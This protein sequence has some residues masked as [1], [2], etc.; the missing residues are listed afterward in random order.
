MRVFCFLPRK[1]AH[2]SVELHFGNRLASQLPN[3]LDGRADGNAS[4]LLLRHFSVCSAMRRAISTRRLTAS[5]AMLDR[6]RP[7]IAARDRYACFLSSAQEAGVQICRLA[8]GNRLA[9]QL[10]IQLDGRADVNAGVLLLR[11]F[12][13][14]S[15]MRRA[16]TQHASTH[17]CECHAGLVAHSSRCACQV[18]VFSAQEVG[19]SR[20]ATQRAY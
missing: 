1:L 12:S 5:S 17:L 3:Q 20:C 19:S 9:S 7:A 13:V 8:F 2:R 11:H 10:P 18:G 16:V 6:S 14:C 15:A 4:V